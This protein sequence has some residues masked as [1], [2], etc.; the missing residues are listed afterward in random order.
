MEIAAQDSA[1]FGW[2]ERDER[3]KVPPL[4]RSAI[5]RY[6]ISELMAGNSRKAILAAA[7]ANFG[8]AV[9]KFVGYSVT[10]AS[11]MLA[12]GVHSVADTG[13]QLLLLWGGAAARRKPTALHPFGFGRERYFWSFVVA[14]VLFLMGSLFAI[15]EGW[16]KMHAP[17]PLQSPLWAVGI[18]TGGI[19]LEGASFWTAIKESKKA[20][21]RAGWWQ[22]IRK[23]RMPEL[24]VVLLEDLGALLGLV[25]ALLGVGLSIWTENP[26]FDAYATLSIGV[27][28][29]VIAVILSIEMK[30]LLIGES[31]QAAKLDAICRAIE[32]HPKVR[33]IIHLKTLH[34]APEEVLVAVKVA[35]EPMEGLSELAKSIDTI[36]TAM[37]RRCEGLILRIY[38]EPDELRVVGA[39]PS[40][41][42]PSP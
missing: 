29:G 19:L 21:G 5:L 1:A 2:G 3:A 34:L 37:R 7:G 33:Q 15:Y 23:S 36:E 13:N 38:L 18:L 28:L 16:H 11:S 24:P 12:E 20:K 4:L 42:S 8:I 26:I 27:L 35:F 32:E 31:L 40:A 22:F 6:T 10:G 30:S 39:E 17:E 14:L 25:I 41:A 9:A